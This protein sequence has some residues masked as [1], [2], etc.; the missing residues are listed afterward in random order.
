MRVLFLITITVLMFI[1]CSAKEFNDGVNSISG[2]IANAFVN[3][4]DKSAD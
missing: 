3:S 1:G 4:K 2:D